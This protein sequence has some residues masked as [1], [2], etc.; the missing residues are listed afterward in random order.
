[1]EHLVGEWSS[2]LVRLAHLI[3]GIG[4]IGASFYFMWLDA[5]IEAPAKPKPGVEGELWMVH[6]GGF[7]RVEKI[8]VSPDEMPPHLHW[9]RWEAAFTWASGFLLLI[10]TYYA[11]AGV[12]LVDPAKADLSPLVATAIGVGTLLGGFLVYEAIWRS[13]YGRTG[14]PPLIVCV[15]LLIGIAWG[16]SQIFSGRGAYIHVGALMGT[17][18]SASVWTVIVPA[19][20]QLVAASRAGRKGDPALAAAAKQRSVHNNY[21]TLP[22]V[23][24]MLSGHYPSLFGHPQSWL[25]LTLA[26]FVVGGVN[27]FINLAHRGRA[28]PWPLVASAALFV[29]L[30]ILTAQPQ[31]AAALKPGEAAVDFAEVR[32]VIAQRCTTCHSQTPTDE[33]FQQPPNG[34]MLDTP[35]Q[36]RRQ[37]QKINARSVLTQTM[38]PA[39]K[40][41]IT[42][43]E[44]DLLRRWI[45]QGVRIE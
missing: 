10:L 13:P 36:I 7:Y 32:A 12:Y 16:L 41:E 2:A 29:P 22:V 11:D 21:M 26:A 1:M 38:P 34:M 33:V 43:E 24:I 5:S 40:T 27:H 9:F 44:R 18:M 31:G 30:F 8:H 15:L 39:N 45:A 4:W 17:I 37:A 19:Q 3:F 23:F 35:L 20:R 28:T 6:S 14:W 42:D 25:V